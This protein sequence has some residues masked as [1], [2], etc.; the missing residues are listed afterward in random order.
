MIYGLY[1]SAT[2][3][4]TNSYRQDVIANNLANSET[5]G[6]KKDLALFQQRRTEAQERGFGAGSNALLEGLGGGVYASPT[7]VDTSQGDLEPTGSNLD[8]AIEGTGY[9]NVHDNGQTRLTRD[10]RFSLDRTGQLILANGRGQAVLDVKGRPIQLDPSLANTETTIG[11]YGEITQRGRM[12]AQIGLSDVADPAQ[13]KKLGG[14][15]MSYPDVAGMRPALGVLHANFVEHANVEPAT[16]LTQLMDA[17][18]QLE[19]NANMIRFQDQTLARLV[20][21]VGKIS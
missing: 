5:V 7:R 2:G 18:R 11:K 17:Q 13:L 16:E 12:V 9:F 10:G 1:L 19:A 6:F 8:V 20:N 4:L 15:M 14:N 21:D 3:V